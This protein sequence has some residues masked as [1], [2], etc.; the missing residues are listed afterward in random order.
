MKLFLLS[1][2][3]SLSA[4]ALPFKAFRSGV[5]NLCEKHLIADDPY[6]YETTPAKN[7]E[8][9]VQTHHDRVAWIELRTRLNDPSITAEE[10]VSIQE[11]FDKLN[12]PEE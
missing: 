5:K 11:F 3:I 12:T 8:E 10:K 7:L 1:L 9:L 2:V 4:Q 6:Q